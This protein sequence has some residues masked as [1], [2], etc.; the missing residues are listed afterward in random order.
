MKCWFN[1]NVLNIDDWV[2]LF[3]DRG[4]L[5]GDGIFEILFYCVGVLVLSRVYLECFCVGVD[6][7]DIFLFYFNFDL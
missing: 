4:F 6:I 2:I 1:G 3:Y 5:F 7:L